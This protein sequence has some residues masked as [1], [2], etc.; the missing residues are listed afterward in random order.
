MAVIGPDGKLY[1]RQGAMT[2]RGVLGLDSGDMPW[3][4]TIP[5]PCDI[6]GHDAAL[7]GFKAVTSGLFPGSF[8][9]FGV[10]VCPGQKIA[11]RVPCTFSVMRYAINGSGLELVAWGL[12]NAYGLGFLPDGRMLA[13]DQGADYRGSRPI[14]NCPDFF[15][16]VRDGAWYGWPDFFGSRPATDT[17]F[18][19]PGDPDTQFLLS[20]HAELPQPEV[21]LLEFEVNAC[22]TKFAV[23]PTEFQQYAGHLIVA[24]FGDECSLTGPV[25]SR[26]GRKLVRVALADRSVHPVKPLPFQR[27]IDVYVRAQIAGSLRGGLRRIRDRSRQEHRLP[28]RYRSVVETASR[29]HGCCV[30][31]MLTS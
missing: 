16:E 12:R 20:N 28:R 13:T 6:P 24:L 19:A 8:S 1:F 23:V 2:N 17:G 27:P 25:R 3:L 5:H 7:R 26:V 9:P 10:P 21:P 15:Y 30:I 14:L 31:V 22:A 29:F 18:H 11:G 4:G